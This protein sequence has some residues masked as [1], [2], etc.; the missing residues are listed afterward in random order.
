M[1][2]AGIDTS[3]YTTGF[4]LYELGKDLEVQRQLRQEIKSIADEDIATKIK[5]MRFAKSVLKE[6]LRLHPISVGVSRHTTQECVLSGY[7]IPPGTLLISQNQVSCRLPEFCPGKDPNSF[8]PERWTRESKR[9][10]PIDPYLSL[11]FGFGPRMCIGRRLAEQSILVLLNK[12]LQRYELTWIGTPHL[13]CVS[14]LIN[15]P[16]HPLH[17]D[18]NLKK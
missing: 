5:K 17:F 16:E 4:L 11:P 9:Q 15:R 10:H 12:L 13:D 6:T 2:L 1:L 7:Q 14:N 8:D 3:S 18:F